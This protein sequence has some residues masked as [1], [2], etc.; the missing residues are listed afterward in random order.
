MSEQ[1]KPISSSLS[2][3][4]K[5]FN[6]IYRC[7]YIDEEGK[8]CNKSHIV[9]YCCEEHR[10]HEYEYRKKAEIKCSA[11]LKSG[12]RKGEICGR[13]FCPIKSHKKP[14]AR[15][16][17]NK[18]ENGWNKFQ[19]KHWDE[20]DKGD[21]KETIKTL[22]IMYRKELKLAKQSDTDIDCDSDSDSD[23]NSDTDTDTYT[24]S[25]CWYEPNYNEECFPWYGEGTTWGEVLNHD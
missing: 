17:I 6:Y 11:F 20:A 3:P 22:S 7:H 24:N 18:K 14:N 12:K 13:I 5:V 19:K 10:K 23:S 2:K 8:R 4:I 21:F 16:P 15:K 1:K 9:K 25:N